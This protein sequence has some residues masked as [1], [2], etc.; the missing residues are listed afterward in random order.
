MQIF[1]SLEHPLVIVDV[2]G[3]S[4]V[5]VPHSRR[6]TVGVI[7]MGGGSMQIAFEV[8]RKINFDYAKVSTNLYSCEHTH[9]S[10]PNIQPTP[11][12][13]DHGFSEPNWR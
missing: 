8:T 13:G 4:S 12:T 9:C 7:D 10:F 2:P 3:Q 1:F 11:E 5:S 6:R